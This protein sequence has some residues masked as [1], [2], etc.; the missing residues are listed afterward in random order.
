MTDL[1]KKEERIS[2][3]KTIEDQKL[4]ELKQVASDFI[5]SKKLD[6]EKES[7]IQREIRDK[8]NRDLTFDPKNVKG[9]IL[10]YLN[11]KSHNPSRD[12]EQLQNMIKKRIQSKK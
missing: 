2:Q 5:S 12:H 9:S 4:N 6:Y 11:D 7:Q 10:N 8:K 3:T 1:S